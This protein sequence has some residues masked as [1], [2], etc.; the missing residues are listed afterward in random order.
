MNDLF[1]YNFLVLSILFW[2]PG[3]L[4]LMIRADLRRLIFIMCL[5]SIPFAFTEFLFY[6]NYWEPKF[7]WDLGNRIGFGIEDFLFVTG[8]A[9]FG[10]TAYLVFTGK[11]LQSNAEWKGFGFGIKPFYLLLSLLVF[12]F[13]FVWVFFALQIQMIYGAPI[14]LVF[15]SFLLSA[16]RKDLAFPGIWGGFLTTLVYFLLCFVLELF[17]PKIFELAWHTEQFT[18]IFIG[19]LPLEEVVY[20]F[21][22]GQ[23]ATLVYPF[24]FGY[25]Y[26]SRREILS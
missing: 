4:T 7:L 21:A 9:S 10:T 23:I 15:L 24:C 3:I 12:C 14:I 13:F 5:A 25:S 22:S 1:E 2:V 19:F 17:Y 16:L 18:G 26:V 20:A 6:P 11:V 8:F